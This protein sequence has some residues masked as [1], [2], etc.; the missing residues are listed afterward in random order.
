MKLKPSVPFG[1]TN[2]ANAYFLLD[3]KEAREVAVEAAEVKR[4]QSS[5]PIIANNTIICGS[6]S[7]TC[8]AIQCNFTRETFP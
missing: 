7:F 1:N 4:V 5:T 2:V 6:P 3:A 8:V